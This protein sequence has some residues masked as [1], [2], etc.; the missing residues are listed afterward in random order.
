MF[1]ATGGAAELA[2]SPAPGVQ[3][4]AE[5]ALVPAGDAVALGAALGLFCEGTELR[6]AAAKAARAA[7][8]RYDVE[9]LVS[10]TASLYR[11]LLAE[12]GS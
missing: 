5:G 7:S 12:R 1:K 8:T 2:S 10:E 3:V 6:R 9:R 4:R 11:R